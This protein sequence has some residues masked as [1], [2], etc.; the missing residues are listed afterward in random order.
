MSRFRVFP[1]RQLALAILALACLDQN[2]DAQN[3]APGDVALPPLVVTATRL[4]TPEAEIASS[5]TVITGAEMEQKQERTLP[6][7]LQDVP[8]LNVVQSGGPGSATQVYIRGTNA[9]HVKVLIDGIEI[10]DPSAPDGAFDFAHIL[11]ADIDRVEILRGPQSGL[12]GS[13]AIG[14]VINIITKSGAGPAHIT[15]SV[16]GGSFGTFNQAAGAS[17]SVA[18][19]NYAFDIAH[20]RSDDTPV[21]PLA[22]VPAGRS[23]N[24]DAYDN[25]TASTKLGVALTD[26]LD[27]GLVAR[28]TE[29]D[30][31]F[32][33][34]DFLGPEALPSESTTRQFATRGTA[35]LLSFDGLLDQT[36]GVAFTN[37]LDRTA[38]PNL[39][40]L[41][42]SHGDR[43][44]FDWQGNIKLADTQTLT[45][46]AE[47][48]RA[49]F[50]SNIPVSASLTNNG[51]FAELQSS[52]FDRLF[53]TISVRYDD[54]DTFGS[55]VT[56]RV[57]PAFLIPETGTKLKATLGTGFKAPSLDQLYESFSAFD[58]FA[59]PNLRPET[60]IGYDAG[61]E[62]SFQDKRIQFG[63]TYFHNDITNLIDIND[64][65]TT[66]QNI[67][68][69]TT[70]GVESFVA[71]KP[72]DR[73]T[74][75]GDYTFTIA[76]DD[77]LH[78]E[79]LRRPKDKAS[80]TATWQVTSA[81]SLTPSL[82]YVG[83]WVDVTRAGT[84]SGVPTN[85]Y[86]L[87]NFAGAYDLGHG[88]TAFARI[89]NALDRSYQDPI[90][91]LHPGLG[92]FAGIRVAFDA[93]GAGQ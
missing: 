48:Q 74:L 77:I 62:Q 51:G 16:E 1:A 88:M 32:T 64:A 65:G 17:G 4:P 41:T 37:D 66:Y 27:L 93:M 72:V 46:G 69:A 3:A 53:N 68:K 24:D 63:A 85:G 78:T 90:G 12:Y 9:N 36:F 83:P 52:F 54:Y 18:R 80:V 61:F 10:S 81:F 23:I 73:L 22:L 20:Y 50:D 38:D 30:L 11:T 8:G 19:F 6:E 35:H 75:R 42:L 79:L 43:V 57:A 5:I 39:P 14:G 29:S 31:H 59:N 28:Y 40:D 89:D 25:K 67:G 44:K 82:V 49:A 47:H 34:D 92:V 33:E 45:L 91:F 86:T 55:K 87:L 58:F 56:W 70:Y 60:S 2:A 7:A 84:A 15:G 13:D 71:W 76:E 26:T 21:T